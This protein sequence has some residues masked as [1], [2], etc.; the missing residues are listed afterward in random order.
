MDSVI[1]ILFLIGVLYLIYVCW[2]S[3]TR[4]KFTIDIS[5]L[6]LEKPVSLDMY[7]NDIKYVFI[8]FENLKNEYK[9]IIK[10]FLNE[11]MEFV[12][13]NENIEAIKEGKYYKMPAFIV[14]ESQLKDF[15]EGNVME[16]RLLNS[17]GE[18]TLIPVVN[19]IS[20]SGN[21]M[22]MDTELNVL[23]Y[24]YDSR[25]SFR[26]KVDKDGFVPPRS[27]KIATFGINDLYVISN[28]ISKDT[29]KLQIN[30]K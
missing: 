27:I 25:R 14:K 7:V 5:N 9:E 22:Y 28:D 17:N 26:L 15:T 1:K 16:F 2:T 30:Q 6:N 23:Y 13:Q 12:S 21:L 11:N 19:G 18:F 29:I 20:V 8:S 4:E 24:A 3:E 10:K